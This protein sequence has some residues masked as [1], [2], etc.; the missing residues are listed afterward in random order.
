MSSGSFTCPR[1]RL[2]APFDGAMRFCPRCG[3][4]VGEAVDNQRPMELVMGG[5]KVVV[6][7]RLAFGTICNLYRCTSGSPG[8]ESVFKIA[9]THLSNP[10]VAHESR[11]LNRLLDADR[12]GRLAPFVP[13][14]KA[15]VNYR[16]ADGEPE[17]A[18]TLLNYHDGIN[19]PDELYSL[20]EVRG[21]YPRGID[22]RDMA[23]M[24]R[25]ILTVLGHIH[26]QGV[27]HG[28][29]TPDH[30]LIEP[31]EHKLVL[32]GWCGATEIGQIPRLK[33]GRWSDW[34]TSPHPASSLTDLAGAAK[35]M[36]YLLGAGVEPAISRHL[37]RAGASSAGALQ[38][39]D[40]FDRMIEA[41]WGPRQF[42]VFQMPERN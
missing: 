6:H 28:R 25:R 26:S 39:L 4:A 38:L 17:R 21:A 14:P 22:A 40:D 3:L 24:W 10:H 42:R 11:I 2:Y 20:E 19:G 23:W 37:E 32:V 30:V 33:A 9:R 5:E 29:T 13:R 16:S 18:A 31:R 34:E 41:L 36:A 27:A 7:D 1:C 12:E 15:T 35:T 8:R